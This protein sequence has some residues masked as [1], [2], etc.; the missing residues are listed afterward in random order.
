LG[1]PTDIIQL[2]DKKVR[3]TLLVIF[4]LAGATFGVA[5]LVL[6][7]FEKLDARIVE[8]SLAA[9][10]LGAQ[11]SKNVHENLQ[12]DLDALQ[13]QVNDLSREVKDLQYIHARETRRR[14]DE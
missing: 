1:V 8:K 3:N 4:V 14:R 9:N 10:A 13:R 12:R 5:S 11:A 6:S 2:A 7:S